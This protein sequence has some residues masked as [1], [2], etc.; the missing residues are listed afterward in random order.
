MP[1]RQPA[2]TE[3]RLATAQPSAHIP[4]LTEP[5]CIIH[6]TPSRGPHLRSRARTH[7]L[8]REKRDRDRRGLT[9]AGDST[10]RARRGPSCS[11]AAAPLPRGSSSLKRGL[12]WSEAKGEAQTSS[13]TA[14]SPLPPPSPASFSPRVKYQPRPAPP[15]LAPPGPEGRAA[16]RADTGKCSLGS[17]GTD[18][19]ALSFL[20]VRGGRGAFLCVSWGK[21]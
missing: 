8:E 15:R 18:R 2:A 10:S 12:R 7:T 1:A 6:S 13:A 9:W 19:W 3:C 5:L 17:G 4:S 14:P 20:P 21:T 11:E 16:L